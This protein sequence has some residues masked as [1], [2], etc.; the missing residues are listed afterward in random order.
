MRV[1]GWN[2][3]KVRESL[4]VAPASVPVLFVRITQKLKQEEIFH[5]DPHPRGLVCDCGR[6]AL[7]L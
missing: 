3:K 7:Y 5:K 1:V 2:L 4:S 6:A